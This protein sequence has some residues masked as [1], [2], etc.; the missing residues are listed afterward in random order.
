MRT[1]VSGSSICGKVVCDILR[2]ATWRST[3]HGRK[4]CMVLPIAEGSGTLAESKW[5]KGAHVRARKPVAACGPASLFWT[6]VS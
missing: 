1:V 5:G 4:S 6:N 2:K 3:I